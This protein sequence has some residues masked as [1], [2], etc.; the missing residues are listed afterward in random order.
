[1]SKIL[2]KTGKIIGAGTFAWMWAPG[3][4]TSYATDVSLTLQGS[5]AQE[6]PWICWISCFYSCFW[7]W[8]PPL[9]L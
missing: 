6:S 7:L 1:M 2:R 4:V 8:F 9:S 3:A 5:S